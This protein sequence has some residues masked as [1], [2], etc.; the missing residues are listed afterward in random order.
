MTQRIDR[1]SLAAAVGAYFI[2]G[3]MPL[4]FK[5]LSGVPAIEIISHRIIWAVPLLLIIMAFRHQLGECWA[6][7]AK[8][9][10]LRWLLVSA[11]LISVN[12]LVYVFA[13]N[14]GQ[15]LAASLGYYLNPLL[16]ILLGTVF[17]KEKLNRIQWTAVAIALLAVAVLAVGSL[18]TLWISL[19]LACSF[20]FYGLI[21]KLAP[22]GAIPGLAIE[23]M[24]ML[25]IALGTAYVYASQ[26]MASGWNST[27]STSLL[28]VACGAIT[29]IPLL[30]FAI[31]ARGMPYSIM[32]F[33]QYIG[34]TIQL[35]TA[36]FLYNEMV[37]GARAISFG[38]IWVALT[39]FS[40]DMWRQFRAQ[41]TE[42]AAR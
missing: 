40:W 7:M 2:W 9:A 22:V 8:W 15:I 38:L 34:P 29:A 24:L 16:N 27:V 19:T 39:L 42:P 3:F 1:A 6:A 11:L 12:W 20:G 30:L 17:L 4:F 18:S 32:G 31:G 21:R 28:L 33:I 14:S 41:Q 13:V 37:S 35:I 23:T 5:Q 26:P 10:S 25:P 36:V